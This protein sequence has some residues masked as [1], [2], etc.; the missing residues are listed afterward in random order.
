MT[1]EEATNIRLLEVNSAGIARKQTLEV[2]F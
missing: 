2:Y 1:I